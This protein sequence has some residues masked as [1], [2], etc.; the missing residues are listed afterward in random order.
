LDNSHDPHEAA[1]A[2]IGL[3]LAKYLVT[4]RAPAVVAEAMECLGGVGYVEETPL[5]RIFRQSP[6]NAIWE[7]SGNVIAL[8]LLRVLQREPEAADALLRYLRAAAATGVE[9]ATITGEAG[10]LLAAPV[11]ESSGRRAIERLALLFAAATLK[12]HAPA[13]VSDAYMARRVH[14]RSVTFGAGEAEIDEAAIISRAAI[15]A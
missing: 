8:D 6:L 14:D 3:P 12:R 4:K 13:C 11:L 10:D 9:F 1:L 15:S 7:G 5:A 2:R